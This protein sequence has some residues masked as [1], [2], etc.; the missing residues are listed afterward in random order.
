MNWITAGLKRGPYMLRIAH[1][2]PSHVP[3]AV[4][5]DSLPFCSFCLLYSAGGTR[6]CERT[7]PLLRSRPK[8]PRAPR[9]PPVLRPHAAPKTSGP[10]LM[11][12]LGLSSQSQWPAAFS[13][14]QLSLQLQPC[15]CSWVMTS[16]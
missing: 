1:P 11:G 7:A 13:R 2:F 10:Q 15:L 5:D 3:F 9:S 8:D 6:R 14:S 12:Q 4:V 16:T